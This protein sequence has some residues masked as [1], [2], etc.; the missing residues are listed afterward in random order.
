MEI[1]ETDFGGVWSDYSY[2]CGLGF[3]V[4]FFPL[5]S[6]RCWKGDS[7][8]SGWI[9]SDYDTKGS[10]QWLWHS[11]RFALTFE[12][13]G[14]RLDSP[15]QGVFGN[16]CVTP[17]KGAGDDLRL[18]W[19]VSPSSQ[20]FRDGGD[21][22]HGTAGALCIQLWDFAMLQF[23]ATIKS[24]CFSC[25]SLLPLGSARPVAACVSFRGTTSL[26]SLLS[27]A[28]I[29]LAGP[30]SL[31]PLCLTRATSVPCQPWS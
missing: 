27:E 30:E 21:Q 19:G 25:F 7:S 13:F 24:A 2:S 12:N 15:D 29:A 8:L 22:S 3:S 18:G 26:S 1:T 4:N 31:Q 16:C 10:G 14:W 28:R 5:L 20:P 11:N 17:W 23:S 9:V 6:G